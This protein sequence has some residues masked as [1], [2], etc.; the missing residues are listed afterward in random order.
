[1]CYDVKIRVVVV[2]FCIELDKLC[3]L[4]DAVL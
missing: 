2:K 4:N 1:M 3:S